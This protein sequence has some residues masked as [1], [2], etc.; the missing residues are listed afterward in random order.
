MN[1]RIKAGSDVRVDRH[2]GIIG[3]I[4]RIYVDGKLVAETMDAAA[5]KKIEEKM[6]ERR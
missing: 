6:N 2:A 1:I 3:D 5:V 4:Y